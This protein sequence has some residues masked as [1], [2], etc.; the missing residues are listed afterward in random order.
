VVAVDDPRQLAYT[1]AVGVLLTA[2]YPL[3]RR[4]ARGGADAG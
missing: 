1:V 4:G 2:V 3:V